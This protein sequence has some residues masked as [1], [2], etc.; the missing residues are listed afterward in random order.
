[1]KRNLIGNT[2]Y[3]KPNLITILCV[4][5]RWIEFHRTNSILRI[6]SRKKGGVLNVQMCKRV[7]LKKMY[8]VQD[9]IYK[10]IQLYTSYKTKSVCGIT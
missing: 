5:K 9:I 4:S 10:Y 3:S 8:T 6:L 2:L 1:M 7:L